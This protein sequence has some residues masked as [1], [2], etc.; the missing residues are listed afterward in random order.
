MFSIQHPGLF[1]CLFSTFLQVIPKAMLRVKLRWFVSID[2]HDVH[3]ERWRKSGEFSGPLWP[4]WMPR[5]L[6]KS[7]FLLS[8]KTKFYLHYCSTGTI[9]CLH[10]QMASKQ[11]NHWAPKG[12]KNGASLA[13]SPL[14]L[15]STEIHILNPFQ[16][17]C[18]Q[19]VVIAS[20]KG[21]DPIF[22]RTVLLVC[23][24]AQYWQD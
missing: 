13:L 9:T 14:F 23:T 12:L 4:F 19:L 18:I 15:S 3:L 21:T 7:L 2:A 24:K 5:D 1:I 6:C 11:C 10:L 8:S 20:V 16:T 17:Q 22:P